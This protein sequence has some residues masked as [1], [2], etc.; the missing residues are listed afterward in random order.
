M[1]PPEFIPEN[2]AARG[3]HVVYFVQPVKGGPVKI[4]TTTNLGQRLVSLGSIYGCHMQVLAV[5]HGDKSNEKVIHEQFK[6]YRLGKKEQFRPSLAL[7]AFLGRPELGTDTE[8]S[9]LAN[10][11]GQWTERM[12]RFETTFNATYDANLKAERLRVREARAAAKRSKAVALS[13]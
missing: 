6:E 9:P 4:G 7:M 10:V 5:M 8:V 11:E 13:A 1:L 2:H 12:R 3:V